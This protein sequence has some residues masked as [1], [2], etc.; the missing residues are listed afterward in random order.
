MK[1]TTK[2]LS[3]FLAVLMAFSII[4]M[5]NIETEAAG[6]TLAE[7]RARAEAIVNYT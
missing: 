6:T 3:L 1:K 5:T 2:I 7:M 4:P